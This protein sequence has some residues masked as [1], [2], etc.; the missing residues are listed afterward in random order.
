MNYYESKGYYYLKAIDR[1]GETVKL[2]KFE[3]IFDIQEK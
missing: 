2:F 3:K 1:N